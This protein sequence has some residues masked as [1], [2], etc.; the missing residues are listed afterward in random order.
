[1]ASGRLDAFYEA[2]LKPWDHAAGALVAHEAGASVVMIDWL[3]PG[4]TTTLAAAPGLE[5]P[6]VELLRRAARKTGSV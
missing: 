4:S 5:G 6:L 1:M 3:H 2:E